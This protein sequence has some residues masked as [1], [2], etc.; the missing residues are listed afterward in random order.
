MGSFVPVRP[1]GAVQDVVGQISYAIRRGEYRPGDRL[2]GLDD[3][4][5]ALGTSRPTVRAAYGLLVREG[6][7]DVRRGHNGGAIVRS[8]TVPV[9]VLNAAGLAPTAPVRELLE[10]RRPVETTL[11]HLAGRRAQLSDLTAMAEAIELLGPARGNPT[12]WTRAND[13][14]HYHMAAA[15]GS[16]RLARYAHELMA[17]L[18]ILLDDFDEQ[19]VDF[20][21]TVWV[22]S[23][24][25]AAIR[26]RDERRIDIVMDE[27][28][29]ELEERFA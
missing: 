1:A 10:A 5:A 12:E 18:A 13:L 29:R 15:A 8:A 4:A 9:S 19:Y 7:L 24:T 25:L 14:F 23:E 2:P 6:V 11:A 28:L 21:H 17:E 3:M 27:H 26:S 16:A 20:E 22:H